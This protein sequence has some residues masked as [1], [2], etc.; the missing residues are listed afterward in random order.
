MATRFKSGVWTGFYGQGAKKKK[1]NFSVNFTS[2]GGVSGHGLAEEAG[3]FELDGTVQL[4][5]PY[6][7]ELEFTFG[8]NQKM[9]LNGW[10]EGE[11]GGLFGTWTGVGGNGNFAFEPAKEDEQP[12]MSEML[13]EVTK[14]H[15]AELEA[16]G[17]P[18]YLCEKALEATGGSLQDAVEYITNQAVEESVGNSPGGHEKMNESDPVDPAMLKQLVDFGFSSDLAAM[19]LR[20]TNGDLN[21]ALDW[22]MG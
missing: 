20:Q 4:K 18:K 12:N 8:S 11:K 1:V 17:F 19:A 16:M 7:C 2:S 21:M 5:P 10:R 22:L 13:K 6:S 15:V 9:K 14:K 3:A